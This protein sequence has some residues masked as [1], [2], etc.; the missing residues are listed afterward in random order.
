MSLSLA[1]ERLILRDVVEQDAPTLESY[2]AEPE[3]RH[4]ILSRQ[5]DASRIKAFLHAAPELANEDPR[6]TFH[7]S[8]VAKDSGRLLG[9]CGLSRVLPEATGTRLG[10]HFTHA[11][12]G[13]G[14]ATEAASRLVHFA[15]AELGVH[16][17][18]ADTFAM[19]QAS[20]RVLEKIGMRAHFDSMLWS[21]ARGLCY[22]EA[23]AIVR[24]RIGRKRWHALEEAP[25]SSVAQPSNYA[26]KRTAG[27]G[28]DVS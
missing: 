1:T 24:Y 17:V 16:G 18:H 3:S 26:F 9:I 12:S 27:T 8:V 7:L 19:N 22:G 20:R 2:F 14:Y 11:A 6:T 21:L 10:W 15:F 4:H 28:H 25:L 5:R 13:R 23:R